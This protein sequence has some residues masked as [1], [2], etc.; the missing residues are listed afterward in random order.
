MKIFITG[1]A[2]FLGSHLA[3]RMISLGH[4]VVGVDNLAGGSIDN[5]DDKVE[6]YNVDCNDIDSMREHMKNCDVVFHA[7]CTAHDGL[8]VFS[9]WYI[10]NNTFQNTMSV[11]SAAIHNK[12][13]RFVY[14]SSMSR[15]GEQEV[16]PFHE[17]MTCNPR[18]PYAIAKFAAEQVI[19]QLMP[20]N[21]I[22]YNIVVPHNIIGPRQKYD[23]P[24]RNVAGIM[25]NRILQG[26]QPIIYGDGNQKRC[27]SFIDDVIY[28]LERIVLQEDVVG[29]I[30][31]IGPDEEF[32]TINELAKTISELMDWPF[33]PIYVPDRPL[34]VKYATCLADKARKLVGYETKTTLR[35]GLTK[36]IEDI[37]GKGSREFDYDLVNIEINNESTP[38]TWTERIF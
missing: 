31:N 16:L 36:M 7:A 25:I 18:V 2:G 33:E 34:E 15:Y 22:E 9:P 35:A 6:F 13:K 37:K 11:V 32:V 28:C 10:T 26:K 23:D 14:C 20:L 5:V 38:S 30:I 29:E 21:G 1:V 3:D 4:S 24:Y 19:Q 17:E 8:S 12:V 27:F